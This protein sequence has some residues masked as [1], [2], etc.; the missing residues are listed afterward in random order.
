MVWGNPARKPGMGM[1]LEESVAGAAQRCCRKVL[2]EHGMSLPTVP[3]CACLH[4]RER[5]RGAA[6]RGKAKALSAGK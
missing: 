2:E 6:R 1:G 5:S 4:G 3:G